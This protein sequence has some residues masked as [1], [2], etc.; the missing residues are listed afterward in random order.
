MIDEKWVQQVR[1]RRLRQ[2]DQRSCGPSSAV[3]ARMV[4]DPVYAEQ[5]V[6]SFTT[7]VLGVHA[8]ATGPR[9]VTGALQL[10]WPR[11]L[12]TPPWAV[13]NHLAV[14]G[15]PYRSKPARLGRTR[16]F[17][18]LLASLDRG[19]PAP[20]YV[21]SRWLPRHVVL[22]IAPAVDGDDLRC[23][24][25]AQGTV[26]EVTRAAFTGGKLGLSGWDVPWFVIVPRD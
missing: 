11:S 15:T 7:E 4:T 12:G 3:V 13:A 18:E 10:P 14:T 20:F 26:T 21:G 6:D 8:R 16:A 25:P 5:V 23:Y 1:R 19:L 2:P 9:A 24:D 17:D 22:A